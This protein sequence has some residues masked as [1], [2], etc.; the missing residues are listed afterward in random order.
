MRSEQVQY[1]TFGAASTSAAKA[2]SYADPERR[3]EFITFS[4]ADCLQFS[5]LSVQAPQETLS[6]G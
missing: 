5:D 6:L 1:L 4:K 2:N 3:D